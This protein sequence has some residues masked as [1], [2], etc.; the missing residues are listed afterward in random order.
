MSTQ[1]QASKPLAVFVHIPRTGGTTLWSIIRRLYSPGR[2]VR[3]MEGTSEENAVALRSI[4]ETRP[5]D[6]DLVGGHLRPFEVIE[7]ASRPVQYVTML[8]HPAG[9]AISKYYKVLRKD[10]QPLHGE[11]VEGDIP[12][13]DG[14][15]RLVA[16]I[17][18]RTLAGLGAE[19]DCTRD[20]LERA[21]VVLTEQFATFGLLERYD[22]SMIMFKR[23]LGWSMPVYVRRNVSHNRPKAPQDAARERATEHNSLDV[24]LFEYALA[25]FDQRVAEAG[26]GFQR[27]LG[28]F[29]MHNRLFKLKQQVGQ[30]RRQLRGEDA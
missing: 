11:F 3:I 12:V 26:E 24:E 1:A 20:D 9:Q 14:V 6:Y 13:E 4:L 29:A 22:A 8:R 28:R 27:E 15:L 7:A 19:D 16:N 23:A 10:S 21:K 30:V 25:L 17:Q 5:N 18:T 2:W